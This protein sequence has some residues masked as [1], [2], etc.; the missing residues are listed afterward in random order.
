MSKIMLAYIY[1]ISVHDPLDI[2][3]IF[4]RSF[5]GHFLPFGLEGRG[6]G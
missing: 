3:S 4:Y 1:K 6:F 2:E 5:F